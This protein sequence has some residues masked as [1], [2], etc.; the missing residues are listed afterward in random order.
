MRPEDALTYSQLLYDNKASTMERVAK[1][2]ARDPNWLQRI[3]VFDVDAHD[4][5]QVGDF[6]LYERHSY[7]RMR[8]LT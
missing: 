2:I 5:I 8:Y 3:G 4:I 6:M 1:I 7:M